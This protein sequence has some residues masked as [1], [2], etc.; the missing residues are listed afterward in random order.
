MVVSLYRFKS[1]QSDKESASASEQGVSEVG[2]AAWSAGPQILREKHINPNISI[3]FI[4]LYEIN[5]NNYF[6]TF[7]D[8]N[9]N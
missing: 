3:D 7:I 6:N 1:T 4:F 8:K 9:N 2:W 5:K